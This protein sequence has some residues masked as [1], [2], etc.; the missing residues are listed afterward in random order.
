MRK[1]LISMKEAAEELGLSKAAMSRL[2]RRL[3]LTVFRSPRDRRQKLLDKEELV[4]AMEPKPER[5]VIPAL[6]IERARE[7]QRRLLRRRKGKLL[8]DSAKLI[9]SAREERGEAL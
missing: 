5:G 6:A 3:G 1:R 4:K 8:E 9:R 2:V 7:F